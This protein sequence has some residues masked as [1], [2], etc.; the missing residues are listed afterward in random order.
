MSGEHLGSTK[1]AQVAIVVHDIEAAAQRYAQIL[2]LPVPNIITTEP[3][4]QVEMTY[5]GQ[6]SDAQAKLAFFDLGGVQLELIQPLGGDSTWQEGLDQNGEGVH[7]LAF[8]VE[9]MQ[10]SVDFLKTHDIPMIQRGDMGEGQYVY[11]DAEDKLGV[12]VELLEKRR[13]SRAV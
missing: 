1:L 10:R 9:G 11:C 5:R 2:G 4:S 6:P 7:H 12:V 3:G 8:W 13:D